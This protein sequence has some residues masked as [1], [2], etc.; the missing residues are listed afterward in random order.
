NIGIDHLIKFKTRIYAG[1]FNCA[2]ADCQTGSGQIWSS[3]TGNPG[4]WTQVVGDGFGDNVNAEISRFAVF[5]NQLYA[6]TWSYNS[7]VHGTEVW[8]SSTGNPG[9]W[10]R[11]VAN[12][13]N[14]DSENAVLLS[15]ESFNGYL[16]AGTINNNTGA[17]VWRSATGNLG[18]WTQ[19]NTDGFG[20]GENYVT[21][22]AAFK[23]FLY[24]LAGGPYDG[25]G[26]DIWRCQICDGSDWAPIAT[27]G[28]GDSNSVGSSALEVVNDRLYLVLRNRATGMQV[29]MTSNGLDWTQI[30]FNGFGDYSNFEPYWDNSVTGFNNHLYVGDINYG[31]GGE[32]WRTR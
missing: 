15:F 5:N 8:R 23:G 30:G 20:A 3:G 17:E 31:N 11:V 32:I 24:A 12:G 7:A 29:W 16:Y 13:F 18:N 27:N 26:N 6:G 1:T 21:A 2:N 28:F 14:G 4:S 9:S 19:V 22:L 25:H 10:N